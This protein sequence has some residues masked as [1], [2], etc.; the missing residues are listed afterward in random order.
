[1]ATTSLSRTFNYTSRNF[2]DIRQELIN[3]VNQY[4]P[5]IAPSFAADSGIGSLLLEL[6]AGVGDILSN[7]TDRIFQETQLQYAQ[8]NQSILNLAKNMGLNVGGK[9]ASVTLAEFKITVPVL[10]DSFD[11]SYC[12]ILKAG[13]QIIGAGQSFELTEDLDFNSPFSPLGN[14]NRTIIPNIDALERV[15]SYDIVKQHPVYNGQTKTYRLPVRTSQSALQLVLPENNVVEIVSVI[16]KSGVVD[17]TPTYD[18][19]QEPNL[20]YYEVDYLAQPHVF[21]ENTSIQNTGDIKAGKILDVTKKFIKEYSEKGYCLLTFGLGN[22]DLDLFSEAISNTGFDGLTSYLLNTSL[23]EKIPSNST[24]FVKY[25]IGGGSQSNVGPNVLNRLGNIVFNVNGARP[26]KNQSVT[27]SLTVTNTIPAF[28]GADNLSIEQIRYL[29]AYNNASQNRCVTLQ[30]YLVKTYLMPG[31]YG[32]PFKINVL[33]EDNKVVIVIIGK[34][35][36]GSLNNTSTSLL[37]ENIAEW[38]S[39]FRMINDYVEIRDGQVYNIG[40]NIEVY[41]DDKS[42]TLE[43]VNQIILQVQN[44]HDLNKANMGEDIFL[45]NLIEAINNVSGVIN[46][47]NLKAFNLVGGDYSLNEVPMPYSDVNTKEILITDYTLSNSIDGIYEVKFPTRDI[48]ITIKRRNN[49]LN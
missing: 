1:M 13:S 38:I 25:R 16:V 31:K 5:D 7:N 19:F 46:V 44:F 26:D 39:Q 2:A 41:G 11:G 17:Q 45:G 6:M 27:R 14:P 37:K 32:S 29:I 33:K 40:Y 20:K 34:S 23:G 21:V 42:S 18:E 9:R 8:Q 24:I 49:F 47:L 22:G 10:G 15:I 35:G 12:G 43:I 48:K 4:Y 3:Y 30:D 28:G 36:D